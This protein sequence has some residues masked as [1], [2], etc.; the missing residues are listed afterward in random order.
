MKIWMTVLLFS[1]A[2]SLNSQASTPTNF[3]FACLNSPET[4]Y[5]QV[6]DRGDEVTVRAAHLYGPGAV[7]VFEGIV[8]AND[9]V[10][11]GKYATAID[12]IG[13]T[14]TFTFPKAN[15]QRR[16]DYLIQCQDFKNAPV[17][18]MNGHKVR[19]LSFYT[20]HM[21]LDTIEVSYELVQMNLYLEIDGESYF[22]PMRYNPRDCGTPAKS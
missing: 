16:G 18:M 7:P 2:Y 5:Y 21:M 19:G 13:E 8:S 11:I 17:Q 22:L 1:L 6:I 10:R 12:S 20:T 15:C 9:L 14:Q 3:N 4:A